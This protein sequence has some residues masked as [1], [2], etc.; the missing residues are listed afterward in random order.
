MSRKSIKLDKKDYRILYELDVDARSSY[1]QIG[2]NVGLDKN[3]VRYRVNRLEELG[4]ITGYFTEVDMYKLGFTLYRVYLR[5]E[6]SS[7]QTEKELISF[8]TA[9]PNVGWVF[10]V[11]GKYDLV[12]GAY[13]KSGNEFK[14][15]EREVLNSFGLSIG[16]KDISIFTTMYQFRRTFLTGENIKKRPYVTI[17]A[18][19]QESI[20]K[21]DSEILKDLIRDGR[22]AVY[23]IANRLGIGAHIVSYRIKRLVERKIILG[24]RVMLNNDAMGLEWYKVGFRLKN[25]KPSDRD[26]LLRYLIENPYTMYH[27]ET[28]GG[29]DTD[30]EFI[31]KDIHHL[32][33]I[34]EEMRMK[35]SNIKDFDI[36]MYYKTHKTFTWLPLE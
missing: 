33:N 10:S 22:K 9:N 29:Y 30:P 28:I 2:R 25:S 15:F 7:V 34:I 31:V 13:F 14:A 26:M 5:L 35:F 27:N 36:L 16:S 6:N 19:T 4:V 23:K 24:F 8:L 32:R 21:V 12:L 1:S 11:S 20:D 17:G 3:S 18:T